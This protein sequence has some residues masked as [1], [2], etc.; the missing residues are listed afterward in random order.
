MKH[1]EPCHA[2]APVRR[3]ARVAFAF[4]LAG[5]VAACQVPV[6]GQ[7]PPPALYR[8]TPKSTYDPDLPTV[9][10]QLLVETPLANASIDTTR[11]ALMRRP[12]QIE[13][14]ARAQWTD[15]A[16]LMIQTLIVESFENSGRIVAVGRDVVGLRGDFVLKTEL[17][18]FQVE[19][20]GADRPRAH[21]AIV[22]R[23][24]QMPRRAIIS[25]R[26]FERRVTAR[27]DS[28]DAVIEAF[29]EALGKAL[30]RLVEWALRTGEAARRGS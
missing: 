26:T 21:V 13:Y 1:A 20:S 16:P 4:V 15:R 22:A 6:P 8:L 2:S 9:D 3:R 27:A 11:I 17:R 28:L 24:V 5:L 29:D 19:Y 30:R 14:Y 10:W 12:M 18:E 25:T 23:L 7:G